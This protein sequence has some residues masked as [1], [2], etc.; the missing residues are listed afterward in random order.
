MAK[1]LIGKA[2]H[3]YSRDEISSIDV[4]ILE[5]G[6]GEQLDEY[7]ITIRNDQDSIIINSIEQWNQLDALVRKAFDGLSDS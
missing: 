4:N 5:T 2:N 1:E 3:V 6:E 7:I